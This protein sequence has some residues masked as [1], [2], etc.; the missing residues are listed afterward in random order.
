[1]CAN[2]AEICAEKDDGRHEQA[3]NIKK[4]RSN[5]ILTIR[6]MAFHISRLF[7]GIV[8][9]LCSPS[10]LSHFPLCESYAIVTLNKLNVHVC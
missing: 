7:D 9:V 6:P 4:A 10:N 2:L 3:N 1:M 5:M 8:V